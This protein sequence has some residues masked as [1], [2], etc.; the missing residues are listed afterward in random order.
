MKK[1]ENTIDTFK[2][3][4]PQEAWALNDVFCA[5]EHKLYIVGGYVRDYVLGIK[6]T[7]IDI[8]GTATPQQLEQ[9]LS[10]TDFK[11]TVINKKLGAYKIYQTGSKVEFEYTTLRE[12]KYV[13]GHSPSEVNF[14]LDPVID[15]KRRDFTVNAMYYDLSNDK[16]IDPYNGWQDCLDRV[17]KPVNA[18]VF[19]SDGLRILRLLRIAYTKKMRIPDEVFNNAHLRTYLLRDIAHER[20]AQEIRAIAEYQKSRSTYDFKRLMKY[21]NERIDMGKKNENDIFSA[22]DLLDAI[23][24]LGIVNYIFPKL[25]ASVDM[26]K[27]Y[28]AYQT[29]IV[30]YQFFEIQFPLALAYLTCKTLEELNYE[31]SGA[32]F[33]EILGADGLMFHKTRVKEMTMILDGLLTLRKM[34]DESFYINY[35][36]LYYDVYIELIVYAGA[37]CADRYNPQLERVITTNLL[38]Q[39]NNIPRCMDELAV[40]GY[41]IMERWPFLPT[42]LISSMLECAMIMATKDRRNEKEYLLNELEKFIVRDE[43]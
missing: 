12:E 2:N 37:L 26:D 34:R 4:V 10:S 16:F 42:K 32:F 28:G 39:A 7:D 18:Q 3:K 19:D 9:M 6:T 1:T 40:N 35:V 29:P 14:V 27:F 36:Q 8:C 43:V 21:G 24:A 11:F 33:E 20:I 25:A 30:A 41:D 23:M 17:L 15:S 5:N 22:L 31:L 38:M 13:K